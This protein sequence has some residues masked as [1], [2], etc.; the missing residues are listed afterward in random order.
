MKRFLISTIVVFLL[1]A[2]EGICSNKECVKFAIVDRDKVIS[3]SL[4]FQSI[5]KQVDSEQA[6]FQEDSSKQEEELHKV[7]QEI[8]KQQDILSEEA[9]SQKMREFNESVL[10]VQQDLSQKNMELRESYIAAVKEVLS[11]VKNIASNIAEGENIGLVLFVSKEE[12]VF[13]A[14]D[15]IDISDKTIKVLNK[16]MPSIDI[17]AAHK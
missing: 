1:F 7:K 8:S 15:E 3:E 2:T 12:Q 5:K 13:Y 14:K 4:A 10:K 9:F 11:E 6:T 17:K 16:K